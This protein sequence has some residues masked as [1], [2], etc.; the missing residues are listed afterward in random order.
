M[1]CIAAIYISLNTQNSQEVGT[2]YATS[3]VISPPSDC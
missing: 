1:T 3:G 2:T